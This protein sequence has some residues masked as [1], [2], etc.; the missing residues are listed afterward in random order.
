MWFHPSIG[1]LALKVEYRE[2]QQMIAMQKGMTGRPMLQ[3]YNI[4]K[5]IYMYIYIYY[6]LVAEW[7]HFTVVEI[8]PF[9]TIFARASTRIGDL[10]LLGPDLAVQGLR[11]FRVWKV[12][13]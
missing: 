3:T 1:Q 2:R 11:T 8:I 4:N 6:V 9:N 5:Y 12:R 13:V 10:Q 7:V